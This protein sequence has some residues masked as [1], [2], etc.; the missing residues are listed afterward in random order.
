MSRQSSP[1][2]AFL[3]DIGRSR[4]CPPAGLTEEA[5]AALL[6]HDWP[7]TCASCA[8]CSSGPRSS[9]KAQVLVETRWNKGMAAKRLGLTRTQL[10]GRLR[11]YDLDRPAA[12]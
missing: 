7:G 1:T 10:Y 8:M 2:D 5:K 4:V 11:K 12:R 6:A 3:K 9:V